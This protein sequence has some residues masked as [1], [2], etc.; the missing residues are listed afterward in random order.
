MAYRS[1]HLEGSQTSPR[2][3]DSGRLRRASRL[4]L[5]NP[6]HDLADRRGAA[7]S[8]FSGRLPG[9][10]KSV[11]LP[12]PSLHLR[13]DRKR[14]GSRA[15]GAVRRSRLINPRSISRRD[16]EGITRVRIGTGGSGSPPRPY[17]TNPS[18]KTS[19][20]SRV[21]LSP[22]TFR[23]SSC[24]LW[25]LTK[26]VQTSNTGN[27]VPLRRSASKPFLPQKKTRRRPRRSGRCG[28]RTF[29]SR[30]TGARQ[31]KAGKDIRSPLARMVGSKGYNAELFAEGPYSDRRS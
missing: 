8:L 10:T 28:Q 30:R 20:I 11:V 24:R 31:L 29:G 23:L 21:P 26:V 9:M 17:S 1:K 14:S 6:S 16:I 15:S 22:H 25:E 19:T 3:L 13:I 27:D 18:F 4:T 7:A 2:R 12:Y 5:P